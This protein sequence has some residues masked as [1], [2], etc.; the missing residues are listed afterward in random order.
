[1]LTWTQ[2]RRHVTA[3]ELAAAI[4]RGRVVKEG[5]GIYRLTASPASHA[6]AAQLRGTVSHLSAAEHWGLDLLKDLDTTHVTVD[7][8][9]GRVKAPDGV[10]I[11]YRT[12]P[13]QRRTNGVT[14]VV[15]TVLD[16]ARDCALPDALAVADSALNHGKTTQDELISAAAQARGPHIRRVRQVVSWADG[17]VASAMESAL[18]G[19]LCD[20]G[21]TDFQPQVPIKDSRGDLRHADLGSLKDRVLIEADSFLNHGQRWQL[22]RDAY[23]YDEFV[24]SGYAVL[25]FTW[26]HIMDNREWLVNIVR[27]TLASRTTGK[28]GN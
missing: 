20:A 28:I 8:H 4:G 17:R 1:M 2:L 10:R 25:R 12:I 16:C 6:K 15:R 7:A 5:R 21:L 18:R 22:A 19:V 26:E 24:A 13:T 23:R 3:N 14:D 9:R 11:Y 27:S